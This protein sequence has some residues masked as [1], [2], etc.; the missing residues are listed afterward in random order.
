MLEI[1]SSYF[2]R[3]KQNSFI[4]QSLIT[5][6]LRVF[7]VLILFDLLCFLLQISVLKL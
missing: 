2:Q 7:G 3:V 4:H 5:L 1:I 6:I